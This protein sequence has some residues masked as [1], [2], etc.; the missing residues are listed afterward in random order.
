M[1]V[2]LDSALLFATF[3]SKLLANMLLTDPSSLSPA[4]LGILPASSPLPNDTPGPAQHF[5]SRTH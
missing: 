4:S 3:F 5:P 1:F 2:A